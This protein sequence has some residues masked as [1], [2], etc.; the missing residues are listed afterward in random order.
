MF[1]H[2]LPEDRA[3]LFDFGKPRPVSMWMKN[4]I[5]SLDMIFIRS[6]GTIAAIAENTV[7]NRWMWLASPRPCVAFLR[8]RQAR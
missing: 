5:V 6:D 7:P 1:R 8:W 4:T 3:M 2:I